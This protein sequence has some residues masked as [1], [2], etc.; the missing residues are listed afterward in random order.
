M[1]IC[2]R[3]D[4]IL[5]S[6]QI[7]PALVIFA[8]DA[9]VQDANKLSKKC[10]IIS[11]NLPMIFEEKEELGRLQKLIQ[12]RRPEFTAANFFEIKRSTLLSVIATTTTY[13]IVVLQYNFL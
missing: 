5:F 2:I 4:Y 9:A 10:C 6:V 13:M 7:E 12:D 11:D 1:T 3:Q 8:C